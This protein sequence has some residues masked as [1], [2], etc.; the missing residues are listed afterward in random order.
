MKS[1]QNNQAD[2]IQ[3]V[4]LADE[5]SLKTYLEEKINKDNPFYTD[6]LDRLTENAIVEFKISDN[7]IIG[8]VYLIGQATLYNSEIEVKNDC[9]VIKSN[10]SESHLTSNDKGLLFK[11]KDS[12]ANIQLLKSNQND[13]SPDTKEA[14]E[15]Y[16]Q[17]EKE[18]Q[19]FDA[20]LG[21]WQKE[22]FVDESGKKTENEYLYSIVNGVHENSEGKAFEI[23][24]KAIIIRRKFY[25]RI[26][27]PNM[28]RKRF[29][30]SDGHRTLKIKL[31][32]GKVIT[33]NGFFD[34]NTVSEPPYNKATLIYDHFTSENGN[35]TIV[36]DLH[37]LDC[38]HKYY[39]TI[40]KSNFEEMLARLKQ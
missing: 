19:A 10:E 12:E 21:K 36:I 20:D 17:R 38:S 26:F 39:F 24:V 31:P 4:F 14:I 22:H 1:D 6:V 25:F 27:Y 5:D 32:N 3:G 8:F 2:K 29:H 37:I 33:E 28:Q 13:L 34:N 23:Y 35:F 16:E 15:I 7:S 11:R 40:C 30:P 18:K 9:I